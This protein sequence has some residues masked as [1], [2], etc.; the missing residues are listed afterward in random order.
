VKTGN[1]M[2]KGLI[3]AQNLT[4][5]HLVHNLRIYII[6]YCRYGGLHLLQV[7]VLELDTLII[8]NS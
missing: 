1:K 2:E 5:N 6:R 7:V 4:L 3:L 8:I